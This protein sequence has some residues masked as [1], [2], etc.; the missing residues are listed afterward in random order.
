MRADRLHVV[1]VEGAVTELHRFGGEGFMDDVDVSADFLGFRHYTIP[2]L[3]ETMQFVDHGFI[4]WPGEEGAAEVAGIREVAFDLRKSIVVTLGARAVLLFDGRRRAERRFPVTP[5]MVAGTTLG[6][7]DAF[8]AWYLDELW[9][10]L[11]H[12]AA[13]AQG[14]VGGAMA[15]V[16]ERPLPDN[17]Y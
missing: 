17:A 3:A 4:G 15:T 11:D 9:R 16:W 2:R 8:I 12:D 1:L 13:V 5:V 6:C 10:S 14:M 7:G